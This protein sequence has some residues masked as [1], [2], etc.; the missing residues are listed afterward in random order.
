MSV[1]TLRCGRFAVDLSRP[2]VMGIVNVTPDSFADGGSCLD[3]ARAIERARQQVADGAAIVDI[4]GES[5]RPGAAEVP[6]SDELARVVPVVAALAADGVVVSVDTRKPAVM[7]AAFAAG[8]AMVNDVSAL[9]APGAIAAC[10]DAGV[11]VCL[12][13]MRGAPATMQQAPDY[14]DVVVEVCEFLLQRARACEAAGIGRE[15]IVL[16]PGFGFGKTLAH[17]LALLHG[18]DALVATGYPVLAGL[19]R[20]SMLGL[21]TGRPVEERLAASVAAAIAAV[22]RGAAIVRVHDV[23]ETVDALKVWHA[24]RQD[25]DRR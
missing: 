22:A 12:M 16:D 20:K 2:Q 6:E 8:A 19:S 9:A 23:R 11:G 15:R 10:A 5:T 7:R 17:N 3:P 24:T 18:L 4:G 25:P 13:H 14:A 21:L 1:A